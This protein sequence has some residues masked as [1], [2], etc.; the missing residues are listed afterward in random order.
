M[1]HHSDTWV[2]ATNDKETLL[3]VNL[4]RLIIKICKSKNIIL[5]LGPDGS[6]KTSIT[7]EVCN[8]IPNEMK[9]V[10]MHAEAL[11]LLN[12][13]LV[14]LLFKL[15][16]YQ[17]RFSKRGVTGTGLRILCHFIRY[18]EM[19]SRLLSIDGKF[20]F[21]GYVLADRYSY[22]YFLRRLDE[23]NRKLERILYY[24]LFPKPKYVFLLVGSPKT[25]HKR[26]PDLKEAEISLTIQKYKDF[27]DKEKIPFLEINTTENTKEECVRIILQHINLLEF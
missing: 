1:F 2:G 17:T 12:R 3:K 13:P 4:F 9:R 25:I 22:D 19:Y 6:G 11:E 10:Y 18:I 7:N 20:L 26:D 15:G 14:K 21:K 23:N 27:L 8:S 16:S 24:K 5:F